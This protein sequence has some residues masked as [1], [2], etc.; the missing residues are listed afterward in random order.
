MYY[1]LILYYIMYTMYNMCV[2]MYNKAVIK[3]YPLNGRYRS[4]TQ[5]SSFLIE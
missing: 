2:S 3:Q 4:Y 1:I 5:Y